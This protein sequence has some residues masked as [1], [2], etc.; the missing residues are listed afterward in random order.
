MRLLTFAT[1]ARPDAPRVGATV[2]KSTGE[3]TLAYLPAGTYT[4]VITSEGRATSIVTSVPVA[5]V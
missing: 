3:F 5:G 1:R 4:V 2:P